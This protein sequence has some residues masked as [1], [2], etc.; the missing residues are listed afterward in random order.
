[1][2]VQRFPSETT[3]SSQ[4]G[5]DVRQHDAPRTL[6]QRRG[7]PP[8][9][10][11][12][13]FQDGSGHGAPTSRGCGLVGIDSERY[14]RGGGGGGCWFIAAPI[15]RFARWRCSAALAVGA[16]RLMCVCACVCVFPL[17]P[18]YAICCVVLVGAFGGEG[19]FF[20]FDG[21]R[22]L[23]FAEPWP[24]LRRS[25]RGCGLVGEDTCLFGA[26]RAKLTC[27]PTI[28]SHNLV[29]CVFLC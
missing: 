11:D 9:P 18:V 2:G 4:R 6:Q 25:D 1:M 13:D 12:I 3:G 20:L 15:A 21:G 24:W 22:C 28:R 29:N 27:R 23:G 10:A 19:C 17:E 14:K 16:W 26:S 7:P 5:V 8:R